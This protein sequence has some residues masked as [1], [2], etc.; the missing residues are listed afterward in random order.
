MKASRG[1][2]GQV[3]GFFRGKYIKDHSSDWFEQMWEEEEL[4]GP[5]VS[6]LKNQ[7]NSVVINW[8]GKHCQG[9]NFGARDTEFGFELAKV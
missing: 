3:K 9:S 6:S 4:Q 5:Q 2:Q 7:D 8:N 1:K